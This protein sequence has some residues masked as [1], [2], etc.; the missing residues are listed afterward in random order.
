MPE[1]ANLVAHTDPDV[2]VLAETKIDHIVHPSE[3]LPDGATHKDR[4]RSGG[5]VMLAFKSCY[6]VETIAL[7]DV[8]A[9]AA[10]PSILVNKCQKLVVGVFYRQP[11]RRTC[12]VENLEK[13]LYQISEKYKNSPNTT[14]MLSGGFKAGDINWGLGTVLD[15]SNHSL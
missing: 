1:L 7:E 3:F 6:S 15:N 4:S 8:D 14:Y 9:E 11:D 2:L 12:Q 5:G 13:T 10:W